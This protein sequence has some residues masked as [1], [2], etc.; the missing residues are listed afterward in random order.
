MNAWRVLA[1][2]VLVSHLLVVLFVVAGLAVIVTGNLRGW[3][4]VN[5]PWL[6]ALHLGAIA[7]VAVQAWMGATC[8]VTT[9]ESWLRTRGGEDGYAQGFI[10]H[11]VQALL[12][13][14]APAW[15]F[16]LAYTAFGGLVAWAWWRWPPRRAASP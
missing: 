5:R 15:V 10:E 7:F 4:W 13:H 9:L 14:Q 8:P 12:F 11:W 16:T 1:D 2:A 6:R 3:T